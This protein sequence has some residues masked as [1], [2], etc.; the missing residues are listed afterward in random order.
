MIRLDL[1]LFGPSLSMATTDIFDVTISVPAESG[2]RS[3]GDLLRVLA[4]RG[5]AAQAAAAETRA[6]DRARERNEWI[7]NAIETCQATIEDAISR[8]HMQKLAE[9]AVEKGYDSME[10]PGIDWVFP[11]GPD[12]RNRSHINGFPIKTAVLG[13]T[14]EWALPF[15]SAL[16]NLN[17]DVAEKY[18]MNIALQKRP[19]GETYI[20]S[21]G[22]RRNVMRMVFFIVWDMPHYKKR[23]DEYH[24][25]RTQTQ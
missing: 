25:R 6:Q 21:Y 11:A 19:T 22:N 13:D 10:I 9:L 17:K 15:P 24:A 18:G 4:A 12:H 2:T 16:D 1:L 8:M 14:G 5:R 3:Y 20:D 7:R 23:Q